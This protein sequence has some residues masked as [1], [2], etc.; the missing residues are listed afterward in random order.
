MWC[1]FCKT[2]HVNSALLRGCDSKHHIIEI[3]FETK[4]SA[5]KCQFCL[6]F[7]AFSPWFLRL[8]PIPADVAAHLQLV[9]QLPAALDKPVS[10]S[11]AL[12]VC[13]VPVSGTSLAQLSLVVQFLTLTF[14]SLVFSVCL[15][16][17]GVPTLSCPDQEIHHV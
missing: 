8:P 17:L 5:R 13:C 10:S 2:A 14:R 16:T 6:F 15:S 11:R 12:P 9:V 4:H 3:D 7:F 1:T